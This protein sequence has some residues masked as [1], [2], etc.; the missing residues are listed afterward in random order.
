MGVKFWE[1]RVVPVHA[2]SRA[3]AAVAVAAVLLVPVAAT[4][5]SDATAGAA[6][7]VG[8]TGT[9]A[10]AGTAG[11]AGSTRAD[12]IAGTAGVAQPTAEDE[13][14]PIGPLEWLD[15]ERA[16]SHS[17]GSGITVAVVDSGVDASHD[18]LSGRVLAGADF[19]DGSTD[20]RTD[21]VGHGTAVAS[22]IAGSR[23]GLAPDATILPVRV[24]DEENRYRSASTVAEGVIWAVRHGADVINLSLG[25]AGRSPTLRAAIDMAMAHDVVIVACTGNLKDDEHVQVW[26]PAREP[27]VIAVAGLTWS[28]DGPA[29]WERSVTGRETVLAA[30]ALLIAAA[31]GDGYRQVQGTS[32][33]AALVTAAAAL[34]RARWPEAPAGEVVYRLVTTA[35]DLGEPGRDRLY[36]FGMVDPVEALTAE[37]SRVSGNPLDT[38]ARHG[39][40]ALGPAPSPT[41]EPDGTPVRPPHHDRER[42]GAA[43]EPGGEAPGSTAAGWALAGGLLVA[44][45]V[46]L[47]AATVGPVRRRTRSR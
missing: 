23:S 33:S 2:R 42:S 3:V 29:H 27:G 25:G 24:L 40:G 10:S 15:P 38:R 47:L 12:K 44:V 32:F 5:A 14:A 26:Y 1:N 7:S 37:L 35:D 11:T 28:A 17:T 39:D 41:P 16:W 43:V 46:P 9:A 34:V 36:G 22:L 20:G 6:A 19:V 4:G 13:A 18:E 21:P 30:P 8:A 31:P 45:G